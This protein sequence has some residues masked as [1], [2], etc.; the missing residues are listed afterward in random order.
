M[1]KKAIGKITYPPESNLKLYLE[2]IKVRGLLS[3]IPEGYH[4]WLVLNVDNLLWPKR[5]EI[6]PSPEVWEREV[7]KSGISSEKFSLMLIQLNEIGQCAIDSWH[8][9]GKTTGSYPGL[10]LPDFPEAIVID[11]VK[12]L[13]IS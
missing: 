9:Y 5:P 8:R 2:V 3:F 10:Q 6:K 7:I 12:G 13:T 4:I 1:N 11:E